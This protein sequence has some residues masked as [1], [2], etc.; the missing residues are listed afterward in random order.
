VIETV[1]VNQ[2]SWEDLPAE[3]PVGNRGIFAAAGFQAVIRPT[4]RRVVTR[5]DFQPEEEPDD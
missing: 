5:I 3:R 4:V 2:A 1:P